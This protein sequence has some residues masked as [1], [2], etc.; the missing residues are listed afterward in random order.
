M[1]PPSHSD[2]LPAAAATTA[3]IPLRTGGKSR[4]DGTLDVGR[5]GGLVLA[6]LDDVLE[7]LHAAGLEDV[8]VL[9]GDTEA[10]SAAQARGLEA[11]LDADL[12]SSGTS[13]PDDG[14]DVGRDGSDGDVRLRRAVDAG[15]LA[16][17]TDRVRLV[18]AA[19]LP[20]LRPMDVRAVLR[21]P[22]DVTVAPTR[23]GGTALLRLARGTS[24]P[25][26]Y[27]PGSAAAHLAVASASGLSAVA[28]DLAGARSDIDGAADLRALDVALEHARATASSR[29]PGAGA[30]E[31]AD[32][33]QG[34][35]DMLPVGRATASFLAVPR[36]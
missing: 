2:G 5:R 20:L 36:G 22:T 16:V 34:A 8:R 11:L 18:V 27:G 29:F 3:L 6:M 4:L 28:I 19:D 17:G 15:L 32:D 24:I 7:A 31:Y 25:T 9:A 30:D 1:T 13:S 12:A 26:R 21:S 10:A 35:P 23:G 33:S 14:S